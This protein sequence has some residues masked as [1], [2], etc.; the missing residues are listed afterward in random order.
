MEKTFTQ[1]LLISVFSILSTLSFSQQPF[2]TIWDTTKESGIGSS[3]TI[4]KFPGHGSNY[5]I[6]W[7]MLEDSEVNGSLMATNTVDIDLPQSGMYRV[8]VYPGL[9]RIV[10]DQWSDRRKLLFIEQWGDIEWSSMEDAFMGCQNMDITATDAPDLSKV[11]T[12]NGMFNGCS[13]LQADLNH[14]NTSNVRN[15]SSLFVTAFRFNG[16]ISDWNTSNVTNMNNMFS[17]AYAFN[18]DINNW[19]VSKVTNM[20][21]MFEFASSFNGDLDKWNT[22][23]VLYMNDM[24]SWAEEFNGDI[25]TWNTS[26]VTDMSRMF[27]YARVFNSDISGWN[28]SRVANMSSMFENAVMFNQEIGGWDVSQVRNMSRCFLDANTFN[29]NISEWNTS[30]VTDMHDMFNRASMFNQEI[31]GWDVSQVRNMNSMFFFS[32][33]FNQNLGF[34]KLN[35][36]VDISQMFDYSGMNCANYSAT[37]AGWC[38][39]SPQVNNL[40]LG[41]VNVR[42]DSIVIDIRNILI[43]RGWTITG[44]QLAFFSCVDCSGFAVETIAETNI[45]E[46][47]DITAET[48]D[49]LVLDYNWSSGS[50]TSIV[51]DLTTGNYS[52]SVVF[53]NGCKASDEIFVESGIELKVT[54]ENRENTLIAIAEGGSSPYT[55]LWNT[56]E[57]SDTISPDASGQYYVE[58]TDAAGCTRTNFIE[59][60]LTSVS[61]QSPHRLNIYP[62]PVS[63]LLYVESNIQLLPLETNAILYNLNGRKMLEQALYHSVSTIDVNGLPKGVYI[64]KI[65]NRKWNIA[66][67]VVVR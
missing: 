17:Y 50:K 60:I 8:S 27:H 31:G 4:I 19:D 28:T 49:S 14:W 32:T 42:Y 18:G 63:Q 25:S 62:N 30:K 44:D 48:T 65:E 26:K 55:Y 1:I 39:N 51:N 3:N 56:G 40:T 5:L 54:I 20:R 67:K 24:F 58:V 12:M 22:S 35:S 33:R 2:I 21:Y 29:G 36:S 11:T 43:E 16:N 34:W 13:S 46:L 57:V 10:F 52:V 53:Y 7:E 15:M 66:Q 41:A 61:I 23:N 64:L 9:H 45:C 6:E 38:Y 47:V 59:F 37:L